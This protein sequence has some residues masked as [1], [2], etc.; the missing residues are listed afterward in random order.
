MK[1]KTISVVGLG[2]IGVPTAAI[3]ASK[4]Q[5]VIGLDVNYETVQTI[6]EGKIHIVEPELEALV[7]MVVQDGFLKATTTPEPAD[8]FV[9]AVPTPL[10]EQHEPDLNYLQAAIHAVAEVLKVGNLLIIE[11]TS[12]V[13]TT[14]LAAQWLKNL[15]PDLQMP[16]PTEPQPSIHL[17][18]CPERAL[19]GKLLGEIITNDRVIGGITSECA[20]AAAAVYQLFVTGKIYQTD[21]RTAELCK[22]TENSYRDL[23]IAF[24]NEL[25]M[26]CE[27]IGVDVWELIRMANRHPRVNILQPGPGVG[28]HCIAIDPWFLAHLSLNETRLIQ[29]ARRVND[30]KTRWS[31]Q[32]IR[33]ALDDLLGVHPQKSA[34]DIVL[35]CFGLSFKANIDDMRESPALEI[36]EALARSHPG[37]LWIVEPNIDKLPDSLEEYGRLVETWEAFQRADLRVLLVDHEPFKNLGPVLGPFLDFRGI[38]KN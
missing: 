37:P 38:W 1:G 17:A 12:P 33:Q 23:N 35:A 22:L 16:S 8:V 5:Q 31:L 7:S 14:E 34:Q 2:Y 6:N 19:P 36:V 24:A 27:R 21:A 18:Y 10:K 9:F 29:T 32:K 30:E 3:L 15:R 11:S 20:A 13:G 25:S 4:G 28:G 26:V